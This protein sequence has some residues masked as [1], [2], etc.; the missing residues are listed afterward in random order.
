MRLKIAKLALLIVVASL[1]SVG[2]AVNNGPPYNYPQFDEIYQ[3]VIETREATISAARAGDIDVFGMTGTST[4]AQFSKGGWDLDKASTYIFFYIM[5]NCRDIVPDWAEGAPLGPKPGET[6]Y[7]MNDSRFKQAIACLF[8]K[9]EAIAA[10]WGLS[11]QP[12]YSTLPPACGDVYIHPEAREPGGALTYTY[13]PERA[14]DILTDAGYSNT[15]EAYPG[16]WCYPADAPINASQ[17]VRDI[18][19]WN[20]AL[21]SSTMNAFTNII[22]PYF[23]DFF[24]YELMKVHKLTTDELYEYIGCGYSNF[25][26]TMG[27][28]WRVG[29]FPDFLYSFFHSS[30]NVPGGY[31]EAGIENA[32]LDGYLEDIMSKKTL[33][34]VSQACWDAQEILLYDLPYIPMMARRAFTFFGRG[35]SDQPTPDN[36]GNI[37][38]HLSNWIHT[39]GYGPVTGA[40]YN[41]MHWATEEDG[42][43][44]EPPPNI[45]EG[46][47]MS[48]NPAYSM[49]AYEWDCMDRLLD[50]LIDVDPI[51]KADIPALCNW[52][53]VEDWHDESLGVPEG[54]GQKLTF[55]LRDDICWQDGVPFTSEDCVFSWGFLEQWQCPR[56]LAFWDIYIKSET[57]G[58]YKVICYINMTG[59]FS[60]YDVAGAAALLPKHIYS[61]SDI[62]PELATDPEL[63]KPGEHTIKEIIAYDEAHPEEP[64]IPETAT[65]LEYEYADP[66]TGD[67]VS[68]DTTCLIGTGPWVFHTWTEFPT[69]YMHVVRN[70]NW[71]K[72]PGPY[73]CGIAC[74][75]KVSGWN[76]THWVPPSLD[77]YVLVENYGNKTGVDW[78]NGTIDHELS[79]GPLDVKIWID[80]NA[81]TTPAD[82]NATIDHIDLFNVTKLTGYSTG[83][84]AIGPHNITVRIYGSGLLDQYTHEIYATIME[85]IND[86]GKVNV[87]DIFAAAKAF[88][89]YAFPYHERWDPRCDINFDNKIN[90]K[91]IFAI[92]KKFGWP[93]S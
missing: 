11:Y 80:K 59:L 13:N 4:I 51:T 29:R 18:Y 85:D 72:L 31:N 63:F 83:P 91:D 92:A 82:Y 76:G 39:E 66:D 15:T 26:W 24:G 60:I 5:T 17:P 8:P 58:P 54:C 53:A 71:H 69:E 40:T 49:W 77:F 32:T 87:K 81:D 6:L 84:L 42:S 61:R 62:F 23:E 41:M 93:P 48:L 52:W 35:P 14:L 9:E 68:F 33:E 7:P 3:P 55:Y 50:G 75:T 20:N 19:L 12:I 36:Y 90:V 37:T 34:E 38:R 57:Y 65:W 27:I 16:I 64:N 70:P 44:T 30:M 1:L 28:G 2:F 74:D 47:I 56:Y 79:P 45:V 43:Y 89:S 10:V 25:D 22:M 73:Q 86:D 46:L 21:T 67:P 78:V 88:G